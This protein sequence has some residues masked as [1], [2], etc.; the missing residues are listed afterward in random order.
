M[1][2]DITMNQLSILEH[3]NPK[4]NQVSATVETFDKDLNKLINDLFI[5]L[6]KSEGIGISAPQIGIMQRVSIVHVPDDEY[7]ACTYVNPSILT[8]SA[9]GI[10]EESCLSVPGITGNVIRSTQIRVQAFDAQGNSFEK[11][12]T[13]MHAVCLQHE[14]DHLN[15]KLFI[16][17]LSWLHRMKLNYKFKKQLKAA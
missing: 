9:P 10:V 16:E 2:K 7:G 3:P 6:G 1:M 11:D 15:G 4:L 13:G 5:T 14:I 17:R 12:L 8:K